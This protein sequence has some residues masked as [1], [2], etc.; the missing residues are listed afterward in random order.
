[1]VDPLFVWVWTDLIGPVLLV[2]SLLLSL[3]AGI[4]CLYKL[5]FKRE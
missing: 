3:A 2:F 5:I 1:M 4:A